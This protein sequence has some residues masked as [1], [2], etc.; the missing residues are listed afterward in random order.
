ME[1]LEEQKLDQPLNEQEQ[2]Q[3]EEMAEA[4]AEAGPDHAEAVHDEAMDYLERS[5][6]AMV[7]DGDEHRLME[8]DEN[9]HPI[10]QTTVKTTT[11]ITTEHLRGPP[12]N[13]EGPQETDD[14]FKIYEEEIHFQE[15]EPLTE[16]EKSSTF[17][18]KDEENKLNEGGGDLG[19]ST[20]DNVRRETS[21]GI[22]EEEE[23][24]Q[25]RGSSHHDDDST[26]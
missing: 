25:K 19:I 15:E 7:V 13:I 9:G 8:Y 18:E 10:G 21:N 3:W 17:E 20:Y 5:R 6:K 11:L 23:K 14:P 24:Q 12:I 16:V 2:A 22:N 4:Q 1:Q 26:K